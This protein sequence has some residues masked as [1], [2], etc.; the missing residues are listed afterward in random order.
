MYTGFTTS[1][2]ELRDDFTGEPADG[3]ESAAG[4]DASADVRAPLR[5]VHVSVNQFWLA[6][7]IVVNLVVSAFAHADDEHMRRLWSG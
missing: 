6:G 7:R 5:P 1:T 4:F 2:I 3:G